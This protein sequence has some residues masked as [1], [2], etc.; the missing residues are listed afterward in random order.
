MLYRADARMCV[1]VRVHRET[2]VAQHFLK[3]AVRNAPERF[4]VPRSC[5][6]HRGEIRNA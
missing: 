6:G 5:A 2:R 3:R 4:D 1:A